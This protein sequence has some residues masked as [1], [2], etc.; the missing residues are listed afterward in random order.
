MR[1]FSDPIYLNNV[2]T[3]FSVNDKETNQRNAQV[4]NTGV[5]LKESGGAGSIQQIDFAVRK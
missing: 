3:E 1:A 5:Y 2:S 4:R